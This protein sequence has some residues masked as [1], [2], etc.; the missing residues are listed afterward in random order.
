[1]NRFSGT[2]PILVVSLLTATPRAQD[3]PPP[4]LVPRAALQTESGTSVIRD[5]RVF[6][7]ERGLEHRSVLI[8]NGEIGQIGGAEMRAPGASVVDG[9]NRTLLPGLF[10]THVHVSGNPEPALRQLA[11]M[12]VTT[13]LDMFAGLRYLSAKAANRVGGPA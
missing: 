12:G 2:L 8:V 3:V 11:A 1:M 9:R 10:D 7:G 5:V 13:A 4:L 6:D